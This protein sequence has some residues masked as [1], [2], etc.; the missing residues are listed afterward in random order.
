M[1]SLFTRLHELVATGDG[2]ALIE[3]G[4]SFGG[5][6][7][8]QYGINSN[9]SANGF[10]KCIIKKRDASTS[11][12]KDGNKASPVKKEN[13][14]KSEKENSESDEDENSLAEDSEREEYNEEKPKNE[15]VGEWVALNPFKDLYKVSPIHQLMSEYGPNIAPLT[16]VGTFFNYVG[17]HLLQYVHHVLKRKIFYPRHTVTGITLLKSGEI[18]VNCTQN[19]VKIKRKADGSFSIK[20]GQE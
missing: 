1:L 4:L 14:P 16:V 12:C 8:Q 18:T 13:T 5:G 11:P 15:N 3:M 2:V 6:D 9:T 20:E 7:L 17:N 19:K 10:S